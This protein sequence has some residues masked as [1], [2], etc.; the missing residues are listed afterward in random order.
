MVDLLLLLI[1]Y[2]YITILAISLLLT[3]TYI[4]CMHL[5]AQKMPS[6]FPLWTQMFR[7]V[8]SQNFSEM[9]FTKLSPPSGEGIPLEAR[10][11]EGTTVGEF[12]WA[13]N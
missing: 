11:R 2:S 8:H 13:A 6:K 1:L 12:S 4:H 10:V 5:S 7:F 9:L 3:N